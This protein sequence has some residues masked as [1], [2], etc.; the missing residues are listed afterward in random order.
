[1][2]QSE[3][4]VLIIE[5]FKTLSL[6]LKLQYKKILLTSSFTLCHTFLS[7]SGHSQQRGGV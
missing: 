6:Y 2:E 7:F 4:L 1:M 3:A 5:T